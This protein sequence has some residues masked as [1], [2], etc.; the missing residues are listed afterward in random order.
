MNNKELSVQQQALIKMY[1]KRAKLLPGLV[2]QWVE[3][4]KVSITEIKM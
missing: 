3:E 4:K 2:Q 1:A